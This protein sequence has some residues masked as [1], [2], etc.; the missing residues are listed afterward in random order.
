MISKTIRSWVESKLW[1]VVRKQMTRGRTARG[2]Y[3]MDGYQAAPD[4]PESTDSSQRFG[5]Y[6]FLS[7]VP[8]NCEVIV[9]AIHG[10]ASN[11]VGVA[12]RHPNEPELQGGEVLLWTEYGQ[13][14]LLDKNGDV[15]IY[16]K[17]GGEVRIGDSS[18][19]NVDKVVTAQELRSILNLIKNH[20]HPETGT[21]TAMSP[22][23]ATI[24]LA[25]SPNVKATKP[26]LV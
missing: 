1:A 3:S 4:E 20:Q 22:T 5:H 23:L 25:G 21:T 12:E 7:E 24:S 19:S 11:R 14:V 15:V 16:P 13:R 9:L 18:A 8:N 26:V 10:A 2:Y 6:G 17:T